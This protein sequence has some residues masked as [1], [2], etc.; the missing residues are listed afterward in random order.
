MWWELPLEDIDNP[1]RTMVKKGCG[2][3]LLPEM[4][5]MLAKAS[6]T[7]AETIQRMRQEVVD[8]VGDATV[9]TLLHYQRS[10]PQPEVEEE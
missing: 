6:W 1:G 4:F 5:M 2:Y 9:E 3:A 8:R 7:G 10:L